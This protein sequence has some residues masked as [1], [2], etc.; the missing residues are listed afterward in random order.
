MC[1][2]VLKKTTHKFGVYSRY[3]E[4]V[5]R[6][7][8]TTHPLKCNY[9]DF[10]VFAAMFKHNIIG[11]KMKEQT[12]QVSRPLS[13]PFFSI[14]STDDINSNIEH[15]LLY[16]WRKLVAFIWP[17]IHC[18]MVSID[19]IV[20]IVLNNLSDCEKDEENIKLN[21]TWWNRSCSSFFMVRIEKRTEG[22]Q[23][24]NHLQ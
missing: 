22:K 11:I 15:I 10:I 9:Y 4:K 1:F 21:K 5:C 13:P 8:I 24:L 7:A 12:T 18:A 2:C 14:D 17:K 16:T 6:T 20:P 19:F 23:H 3:E